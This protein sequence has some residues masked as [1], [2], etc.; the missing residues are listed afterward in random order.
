MRIGIIALPLDRQYAGIHIYTKNLIKELSL[1]SSN[2]EIF[3]IR[4]V[5]SSEEFNGVTHV[6]I[7]KKL[8]PFSTLPLLL[9][10]SIPKII[11]KLDLDIVIEPAHFGPFNLPAHIKKVNVI[12]DLTPISHPQWH[13]WHSV[14]GHKLFMKQVANNADLIIANS[15]NTR[16]DIIH[17]LHQTKTKITVA[18]LGISQAYKKTSDP[19]TLQKYGIVR[20]YLLF[21]G[22][23]EPRKNLLSLIKAY[24]LY[25]ETSTTANQQLILSGKKGWGYISLLGEIQ[26]SP[27]KNDIIFLGYVAQK[28]MPAIYSGADV[29]L[30]PSYYEGFGLPILEA[31]ACGVPVVTS[32]T[33]SM[34]EV[35]GEYA[36]YADPNQS[37]QIATAISNALRLS[38]AH[39]E[40][41]IAYAKSHTWQATAQVIL[42]AMEKIR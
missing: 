31:M 35:G 38:S 15:E 28:D 3:V 7:P 17:F 18:K 41:Q 34:P 37:T 29:F 25:R 14:L 20:S 1:L 16:K 12:H 5:E 21:Q 6:T 13:P 9:F 40:R 2:H 8:W 24:N 39:I 4:E 10:F 26:K 33:S 36:I 27:Y 30:Y 32:T 42:S 19:S 11:K 23:I 22:T